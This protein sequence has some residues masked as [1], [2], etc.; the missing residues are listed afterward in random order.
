MTTGSSFSIEIRAPFKK[1]KG[2][3]SR[4]WFSISDPLFLADLG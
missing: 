2:L 3:S 4:I 1:D